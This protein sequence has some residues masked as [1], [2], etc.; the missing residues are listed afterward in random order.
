M[1]EYFTHFNICYKIC[2]QLIDSPPLLVDSLCGHLRQPFDRDCMDCD[3]AA[4][5]C[6]TREQRR[7]TPHIFHRPHVFAFH[8]AVARD[9]R[10]GSVARRAALRNQLHALRGDAASE[11][12]VLFVGHLGREP[13]LRAVRLIC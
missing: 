1:T 2:W 3:R 8:T 13:V 6:A 12:P 7:N 11:L 4:T 5:S 10:K 9:V